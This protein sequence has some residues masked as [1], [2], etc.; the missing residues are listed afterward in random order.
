MTVYILLL[1]LFSCQMK[2]KKAPII[3]IY[4]AL[5]CIADKRIEVQKPAPDVFWNKKEIIQAKVF[6]SSLWKFYEVAFDQLNNQIMANDNGSYRQGYLWYPSIALLIVLGR[7]NVTSTI[8]EPLQWIMRKDINTKNKN[9]FEKTI[10]EI[11]LLLMQRW[12]DINNFQKEI[13]RI[14]MQIESLDMSMLW[15]KKKP[16]E[17]Y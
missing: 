12:V 6:S 5:W 9:D 3:K 14:E 15:N 4:E 1:L 16:P 17:W 8:I 7:I 13:E 11:D 10:N 2:R